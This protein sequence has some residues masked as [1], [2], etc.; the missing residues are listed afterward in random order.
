VPGKIGALMVQTLRENTATDFN[1]ETAPG[2]GMRVT[3][4]FNHKTP[5]RPKN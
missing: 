4:S 1:V 3:I 5:V 2:R